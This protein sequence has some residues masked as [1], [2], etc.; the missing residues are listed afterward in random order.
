MPVFEYWLCLPASH[1][2]PCVQTVR[3]T[4]SRPHCCWFRGVLPVVPE[5]S[6]VPAMLPRG[7]H[8]AESPRP[9]SSTALPSTSQASYST[10]PQLCPLP[11]T[12][13]DRQEKNGQSG[14]VSLGAF[15]IVKVKT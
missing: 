14:L 1:V 2:R 6:C 13:H 11:S 12:S 10:D 5:P 8:S 3:V 4:Q 9:P 7:G 15:L